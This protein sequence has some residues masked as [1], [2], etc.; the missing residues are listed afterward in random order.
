MKT[1]VGANVMSRVLVGS[2]FVKVLIG[3]IGCDL[4]PPTTSR[5]RETSVAKPL[6][7]HE[8]HEEPG[9]DDRKP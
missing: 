8:Q 1:D 2:I 9:R 3:T 7:H 5:N 6:P 4:S